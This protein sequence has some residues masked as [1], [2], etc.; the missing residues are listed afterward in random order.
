MKLSVKVLCASDS[1]KFISG[2]S[3]AKSPEGQNEMDLWMAW[4]KIKSPSFKSS[5]NEQGIQKYFQ[6]VIFWTKREKK[7]EYHLFLRL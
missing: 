1:V 3:L 7:L 5:L 6:G 4:V 2:S